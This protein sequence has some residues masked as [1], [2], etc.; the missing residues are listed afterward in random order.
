MDLNVVMRGA[1]GVGGD[2]SAGGAVG[3]GVSVEG[4]RE[5]DQ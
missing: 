2:R 1:L 4:T 3:V 5:G